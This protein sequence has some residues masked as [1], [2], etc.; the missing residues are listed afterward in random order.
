MKFVKASK[1]NFPKHQICSR[2]N[3]GHDADKVWWFPGQQLDCMPPPNSSIE[4]CEKYRHLKQVKTSFE[5]LNKMNSNNI[6]VLCVKFL[7]ICFLFCGLETYVYK[8]ISS[9]HG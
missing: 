7:I 4:E 2:N 6:F 8:Q 1:L 9:T 5:K 3:Q